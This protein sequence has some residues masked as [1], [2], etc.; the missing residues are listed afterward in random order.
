M[1]T[2][3]PSKDGRSPLSIL[4]VPLSIFVLFACTATAAPKPVPRLQVLPL[5]DEQAAFVRD[6]TEIARYYF[7]PNLRRPFIFPV[8]G[9]SGRSLT[10]MGHPHEPFSHSHH[11]SFWVAHHSVNGISF[12][13]DHGKGR[14]VTQKIVDYEDKGETSWVTASNVWVD[15]RNHDNPVMLETRR[16]TLQLLPHDEYLLYLDLRLEARPGAPVTLGKTPFGLVGVRMAKTIGVNDGGGEIRN[17][18]GKSGEKALLWKPA[19]W[20]D[21]S[22]P[23]RENVTEGITLMDHPQNPNHPTAFHVRSDGWMGASLTQAAERV[24]EPGRPLRL[25]YALYVHSGKP[26]VEALD[27]VWDDF[28]KTTIPDLN[29]PKKK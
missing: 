23:I 24:I 29:P 1:A 14:I 18:T 11:N 10:R 6:D 8:I 16:Y 9:P 27:K 13:D 15:E 3:F 12:W 2:R 4:S 7:G 20:C 21:Y 5:P 17:S 28:A 22:G 25:R 19:K 26:S